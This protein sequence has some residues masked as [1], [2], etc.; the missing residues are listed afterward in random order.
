MTFKTKETKQKESLTPF[1][2]FQSTN[3]SQTGLLKRRKC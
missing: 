3:A 2:F 1:F